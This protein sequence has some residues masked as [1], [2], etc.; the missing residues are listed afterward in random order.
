MANISDQLANIVTRHS[1]DLMA[2]EN[3]IA[4]QTVSM[5]HNL[6]GDLGADLA[7]IDPT[8]PVRKR[9][10]DERVEALLKQ[11]KETIDTYYSDISRTTGKEIASL[12]KVESKFATASVNSVARAEIATVALSPEQLRAIATTGVIEGIQVADW[13]KKQS[14]D[15]QYKFRSQIQMGMARGEPLQDL[16]RRVRGKETGKKIGY[17]DSHGRQRFTHEFKGGVMDISTRNAEALVRTQVQ[18]VANTARLDTLRANND[19]IKGIEWVSTLDKRTTPIC[20][21]LDG[22]QWDLN[23]KPIG[24]GVGFPGPTAHWRCRSTQIPVLKSWDELAKDENRTLQKKIKEIPPGTRASMNG[25]VAATMNYEDW[26]QTQPKLIQKE[27]LGAGKHRLWSEGK[28]NVSQLID[29]SARILT[30][31]ELEKISTLATSVGSDV[32]ATTKAVS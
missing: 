22:M 6:A 1:V 28:I 23:N 30:V 27:I 21:A 29:N 3:N 2:F 24:H 8:A 32:A 5:L 10:K 13:W 19:V 9:Y 11:T 26:L 18:H 20:M 31:S 17:K 12:V 25:Q 16:I 4:K 14:I 7:K 15:T